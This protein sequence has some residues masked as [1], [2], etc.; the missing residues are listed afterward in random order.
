MPRSG[1][2]INYNLEIINKEYFIVNYK[3]RI[4]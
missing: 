4:L 2:S 3:L 1:I